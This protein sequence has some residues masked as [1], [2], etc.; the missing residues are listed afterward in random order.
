MAEIS[1]H[2]YKKK[3]FTKTFFVRRYG[4]SVRIG[5]GISLPKLQRIRYALACLK[6]IRYAF[7]VNA[8]AAAQVDAGQ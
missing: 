2:F 4:P 5:P 6:K 1:P 8:D 7:A 3:L